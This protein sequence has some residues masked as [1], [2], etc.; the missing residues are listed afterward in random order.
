MKVF[1][2]KGFPRKLMARKSTSSNV[3]NSRLL[4]VVERLTFGPRPGNLEYV[5]SKGLEAFIREQ[6]YPQEI[7]ES[8]QLTRRLSELKTIQLTPVDLYRQTYGSTGTTGRNQL[9]I[10]EAATARLVSAIESRRQLQE[11]MVDFWFNHFSV[12]SGKGLCGLWIGSYEW[13]AIRPHALGKFR[14]LVQATARHPAMLYY[15]DNWQN[16]DPNS[17]GAR[18]QFQGLNENYARELMELHTLGINGGYTQED[19]ITLARILTGWGLV[20]PN[21]PNPDPSGFYFD[22]DRHDSRDK[23]FLGTPIKGGGIEEGEQAI[24][25]LVRHPS[26]ARFISMKLAQ[27]FVLDNPPTELVNEMAQEFQATDGDIQA[28]LIT[29][30][31]SKTFSDPAIYGQKF[32]TPYQY[33]LSLARA[34]DLE[35]P[36]R[37]QLLALSGMMEQQG[38]RLYA[39]LTPDGYPNTQDAWLNPDALLRRV[40]FATSITQMAMDRGKPIDPDALKSTLGNSFSEQTRSVINSQPEDLQAALI[41]GSPEMMYR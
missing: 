9:A 22:R 25:L 35:N 17:P 31:Q 3:V 20:R 6:F 40:S 14:D 29:L 19:V 23:V 24:D 18:G 32:K 7:P 2:C 34:V 10:E 13:S 37:T 15:L 12:F 5:Q 11:V 21:Q 39:C 1:Q 33:F 36:S 16:T 8:P 28:V 26:T 41:L 4:H 27:Y 30:F 38:M